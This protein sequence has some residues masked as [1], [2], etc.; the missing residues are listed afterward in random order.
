MTTK[1]ATLLAI[2]GSSLLS[3]SAFIILI[4]DL[5]YYGALK[6]F[7]NLMYIF[8]YVGLLIFFIHLYSKQK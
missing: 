5:N 7:I 2:I 6:I 4:E 8:G 3:L 1:I